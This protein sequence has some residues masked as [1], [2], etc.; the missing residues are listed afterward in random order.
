MTVKSLY[1]VTRGILITFGTISGFFMEFFPVFSYK[2]LFVGQSVCL[3]SPIWKGALVGRTKALSKMSGMLQ[4]LK[5][6]Q[7]CLNY[8]FLSSCKLFLKRKVHGIT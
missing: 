7:L 3:A 8:L 5:K 6:N 2:P 1:E 4:R